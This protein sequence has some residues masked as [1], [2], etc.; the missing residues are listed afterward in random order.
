MKI[1]ILYIKSFG[2]WSYVYQHKDVNV[3]KMKQ[4]SLRDNGYITWIDIVTEEE[5]LEN[6]AK[7]PNIFNTINV[8]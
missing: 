4:K 6:G 3:V 1:F 7:I 5:L 8:E 2:I